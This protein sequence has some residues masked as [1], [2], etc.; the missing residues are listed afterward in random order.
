MKNLKRL[1]VA[2][3]V[4]AMILSTA[5]FA[6]ASASDIEGE[7]CEEAVEYLMAP[8]LLPATQTVLSNPLGP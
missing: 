3:L 1:A 8:A 4:V 5:G 2:M 6:A 7:P